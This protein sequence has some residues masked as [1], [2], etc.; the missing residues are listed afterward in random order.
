MKPPIRYYGGK[1]C[2]A[3]W[4]CDV[5][6]QY[7]FHTYIEPFG[8]SG[9][10]LF[11]KPVSPVEIY[12][13]IH[14]DLVNM[15]RVLR[16]PDTFDALINFLEFSPYARE[17]FYESRDIIR[18]KKSIPFVAPDIERAGHFFITTQQ[19]F[20]GCQDNWSSIGK[21]KKLQAQYYRRMIE[22]LRV[23]HAR[24]R[25]VHIENIDAVE[26]MRRY[27]NDSQKTMIYCDPPYVATT[28]MSPNIY[29]YELTDEQH[30]ALVQTL[31]TV[32]GHKILSGYESP[33]YQ[34]LLDA[35]WTCLKK[36]YICR[37]SVYKTNRIECLY[38]S[39]NTKPKANLNF[40]ITNK[41]IQ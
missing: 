2:Q 25:H 27:A 14:S 32:P 39:P 36:E 11:A 23:T 17:T 13:D 8:G 4:I 26:C 9:A 18:A 7:K 30:E 41:T 15:F 1:T 28:R 20:S 10:V 24:L 6:R 31:L 3:E 19:S 34:P 21:A 35:G 38:C 16:T 37:S 40:A 33:L 22:R 29:K 5:L 12:N